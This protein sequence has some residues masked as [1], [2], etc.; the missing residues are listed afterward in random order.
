VMMCGVCDSQD[1]K[2]SED[3]NWERNYNV[4]LG[5]WLDQH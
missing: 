1:S 2:H 3:L 4:Q 5:I